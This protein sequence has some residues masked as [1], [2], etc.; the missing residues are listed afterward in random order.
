M[1]ITIINNSKD[2]IIVNDSLHFDVS[3]NCLFQRYG[4]KFDIKS[5]NNTTLNIPNYVSYDLIIN[6]NTKINYYDIMTLLRANLVDSII[7]EYNQIRQVRISDNLPENYQL[8]LIIRPQNRTNELFYDIKIIVLDNNYIIVN[9]KTD[10]TLHI[11]KI[12]EHNNEI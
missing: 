2:G 12:T 3:N 8:W 10:Q 1:V 9:T 11:Y 6:T 5:I 4:N 7:S